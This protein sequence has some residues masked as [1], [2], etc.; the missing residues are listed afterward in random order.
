MTCPQEAGPFRPEML[1]PCPGEGR[2]QTAR[3]AAACAAARARPAVT[4]AARRDTSSTLCPMACAAARSGR[5]SATRAPAA[6]SAAACRRWSMPG[7][8]GHR[9]HD[10]DPLVSGGQ[11]GVGD[12]A[13]TTVHE[14]AAA[15]GD[16]GPH[17]GH[18]AAGAHRIHQAGLPGG[19][20]HHEL[21]G[22]RV[23]G[24]HLERR[25][26][27]VA[28]GQPGLDD[29]APRGLGHGGRGERPVPDAAPAPGPGWCS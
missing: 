11:V 16:R 2:C 12:R 28:G 1:R 6:A 5:T 4:A 23:D 29:L 18:R 21:A 26:G 25:G 27:P 15:D 9:R 14:T 20:K 24:G 8:L 17:A 22:P 7:A 19:V 13:Y 3:T 10:D